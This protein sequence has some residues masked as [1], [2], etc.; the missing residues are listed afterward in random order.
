MPGSLNP[1]PLRARGL[2]LVPLELE[3]LM[4]AREQEQELLMQAREQELL[5]LDLALVLEQHQECPVLVEWPH[6]Q[7]AYLLAFLRV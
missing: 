1:K 6:H 5:V 2:L 3:L 7:L 4:Q